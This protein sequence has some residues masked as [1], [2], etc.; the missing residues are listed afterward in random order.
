MFHNEK[1]CNVREE[2]IQEAAVQLQVTKT[3]RME[4][5]IKKESWSK[6]HGDSSVEMN[7]ACATES[8]TQTGSVL[9][10]V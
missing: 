1:E 3:T 10:A 5:N 9:K 7:V 2:P 4:T 6:S 8:E